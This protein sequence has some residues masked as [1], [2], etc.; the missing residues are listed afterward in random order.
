MVAGF[1]FIKC[2]LGQV[3]TVA[4]KIVESTVFL[5]STLSPAITICW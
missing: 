3:E 1:V 5:R 4:N 2:E